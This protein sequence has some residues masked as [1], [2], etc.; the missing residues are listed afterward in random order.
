MA[1]AGDDEATSA[2][3]VRTVNVLTDILQDVQLDLV[4]PMA[5]SS[6]SSS[7]PT[8]AHK[9]KSKLN[10]SSP[11]PVTAPK[12]NINGTTTST[13]SNSVKLALIRRLWQA[14]RR[15]IPH[16]LL[17]TSGAPERLLAC[18]M[19]SEED[20]TS[21]SS[22][23]YLAEDEEA[24]QAREHWASLC[25]GVIMAC[26]PDALRAFWGYVNSEGEREW[27]WGWDWRERSM[28]WRWFVEQWVGFGEQGEIGA[29]WE[30]A[31]VLLGV[32]FL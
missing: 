25:V 19:K 3:A 18:L 20:L 11:V 17:I 4:V 16:A 29:G 31:V 1:D 15:L 24:G 32:P 27:E 21:S 10:A 22:L 7:T 23:F 5:S 30:G 28:V 14:S 9:F 2:F 6:S 26:N 12:L 8:V 13:F